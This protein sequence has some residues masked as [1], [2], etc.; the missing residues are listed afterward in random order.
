MGRTERYDAVIGAYIKTDLFWYENLTN[1]GFSFSAPKPL[2]APIN[3]T[4][5]STL[6]LFNHIWADL[7]NDG[8]NDLLSFGFVQEDNGYT[9][10][11]NLGAIYFEN[12]STANNVQF[13]LPV[14]DPFGLT[15]NAWFNNG[16]T[17]SAFI[18]NGLADFDK[19]GDMDVAGI[20]LST[21][22]YNFNQ[23]DL[24][25]FISE[26]IGSPSS[27][28]FDS[29][30]FIDIPYISEV[31]LNSTL[32][33][34]LVDF[35]KDGDIDIVSFE[36]ICDSI[37]IGNYGSYCS[38]P[39]SFRALTYYENITNQAH[40]IEGFVFNDLNN[41]NVYDSNEGLRSVS[42]F[43]NNDEK[44]T[45]T[46][47]K[48]AFSFLT[49][50]GNYTLNVQDLNSWNSVPE[51]YDLNLNNVPDTI[52]GYDF[53][54]VPLGGHDISVDISAAPPW[55]GFERPYW[56]HYKNL[57]NF[58]ES[59]T[60][61]FIKDEGLDY[62]DAT[63]SPTSQNNNVFTWNI[64]N[65]PPF[66]EGNVNL[67][68]LINQLNDFGDTLRSCV[69][70]E[71]NNISTIELR[72]DNNLECLDQIV[73]G[74]FDPND[75]LVTPEGFG[76][77]GATTLENEEFTYTVRFQNT[78]E[79]PAINVIIKDTIDTDFDI[80]TFTYI[81]SSHPDIT[82][83]DIDDNRIATFKLKNIFL[84]DSTNNE[85]ESHGF[86]KYSIKPLADK[87]EGTAFTNQAHITFDIADPVATNITTNTYAVIQSVLNKRNTIEVEVF[88]NPFRQLAFIKF[89]NE[90]Q[91]QFTLKVYDING[92]VILT[93][94]SRESFFEIDGTQLSRGQ[95]MFE[96][97]S[98][99]E[100]ASG[101]LIVK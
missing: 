68:L 87:G 90:S 81:T 86:V 66:G 101:K 37:T 75:K 51:K 78:G 20:K 3:G 29:P 48:G 8:D 53:K 93:T 44:V 6:T 80:N 98:I 56:I 76:D 33:F 41:N 65:I 100:Q 94:T 83:V 26:N 36:H 11:I 10:T 18:Y 43:L 23:F 12:I 1:D 63:P 4:I 57:G 79:A 59:F 85:P 28:S 67:T 99:K 96:L 25:F 45:V 40:K 77:E 72:D 95:Y 64:V 17:D 32:N 5:D 97:S 74:A 73:L 89:K 7:D 42:V 14:A 62:I 34:N 84:P 27:P 70:V 9:N 55:W 31:D 60:L 30:K 47:S 50:D 46:N 88:P 15:N 69:D 82:T 91:Q 39:N 61:T 16:G 71:L 49:Q 13:K 52:T 22:G 19:D 35:D 38:D 24:D 92:K 58:T 2:T 21:N 54:L